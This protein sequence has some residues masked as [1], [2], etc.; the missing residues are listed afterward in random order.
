MLCCWLKSSFSANLHPHCLA[1]PFQLHRWFIDPDDVVEV[2]IVVKAHLSESTRFCWFTAE[3][4]GLVL[5]T[6]HC[7]HTRRCL[8]MV[9]ELMSALNFRAISVWSL[10][11][12]VLSSSSNCCAIH[13]AILAVILEGCPPRQ[14]S[15]RPRSCSH[16]KIQQRTVVRVVVRPCW[17]KVRT[18]EETF[19]PL[20][21]DSLSKILWQLSRHRTNRSSKCSLDRLRLRCYVYRCEIRRWYLRNIRNTFAT[22]VCYEF[23]LG[24]LHP[25]FS[26]CTC[27]MRVHILHTRQMRVHI[28]HARQMRGAWLST[29]NRLSSYS[30]SSKSGRLLVLY[31]Y[32]KWLSICQ[33]KP[34]T[35]CLLFIFVTS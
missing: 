13:S 15:S 11:E 35:F 17:C 8:R 9:A 21:G 10:T 33:T 31:A 32:S 23:F 29:F 26:S 34:S 6:A 24:N 16:R 18:M 14:S 2:V 3:I 22:Y 20:S 4:M 28:L 7:N 1:V 12:V 19:S 25:P 27:N 30:L 5:T